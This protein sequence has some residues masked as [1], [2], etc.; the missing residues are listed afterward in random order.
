MEGVNAVS[1]IY[2]T[3]LRSEGLLA[4][5]QDVYDGK[6]NKPAFSYRYGAVDPDFPDECADADASVSGITFYTGA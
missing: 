2:Q 5:C 1:D 4:T 3:W 6:F